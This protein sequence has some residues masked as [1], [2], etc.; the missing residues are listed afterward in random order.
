[1]QT[2][3]PPNGRPPRAFIFLLCLTLVSGCVPAATGEDQPAALEPAREPARA[4]VADDGLLR[5]VAFGDSLTAGLGLP[6]E[7]AYPARLQERLESAGYRAR[8]VNAGVSGET[9]AGGLRRMAWA[10]EGEVHIL[11]LA[12]GGNDG[13]RGLP[14][15][16]MQDNLARMIAVARDSGAQVLLAGMEAPPNLGADYTDRF[17]GTFEQLAAEYEVAYLPFLLEG[18]AGIAELNQAD[19]IHPNAEGAE[20]VAAHVWSALEPMLGAAQGPLAAAA[21]PGG[22]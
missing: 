11:I 12:L 15:D 5:I 17:R 2:V 13:L 16:Q 14:V 7:D 20:R 21:R 22:S 3:P 18:V 8:V 10:L 1:M 4:A 9:T 6:A 19:G